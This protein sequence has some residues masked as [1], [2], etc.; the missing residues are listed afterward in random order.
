MED[1]CSVQSIVD[2]L[3]VPPGLD[4]HGWYP[5]RGVPLRGRVSEFFWPVP[6]YARMLIVLVVGSGQ[7][8]RMNFST[9]VNCRDALN[10]S[11]TWDLFPGIQSIC[12]ENFCGVRSSLWYSQ[13]TVPHSF[14]WLAN[15]FERGVYTLRIVYR[16][17]TCDHLPA[18]GTYAWTVSYCQRNLHEV[19]SAQHRDYEGYY[20]RHV[21]LPLTEPIFGMVMS[22]CQPHM[23]RYT[24]V[25]PQIVACVRNLPM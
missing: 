10:F 23:C 25:Y 3:P 13:S 18:L 5:A 12:L 1:D 22:S 11:C 7:N 6:V 2:V 8:L 17:I 19:S 20:D 9:P 14:Q 16:S 24:I 4:E 21:V 15:R